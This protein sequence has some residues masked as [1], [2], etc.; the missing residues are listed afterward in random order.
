MKTIS[1]NDQ[2]VDVPNIFDAEVLSR[3]F[4]ELT[5]VQDLPKI[6]AYKV[7]A[8][9]FELERPLAHIKMVEEFIKDVDQTYVNPALLSVGLNEHAMLEIRTYV[10]NT[11]GSQLNILLHSY[12]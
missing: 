11:F 1:F 10:K 7:L 12:I 6:E 4:S 2:T 8:R 5:L 9:E 3:V